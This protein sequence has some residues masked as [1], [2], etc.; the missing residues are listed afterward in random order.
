MKLVMD[1]TLKHRVVGL[2][3]IISL[4]AIFAPAIMKKSSERLEHHFSVNM[5]IPKQPLTPRLA[6]ADSKE[7][8]QTIK[9]ARV[10]I[11]SVSA[12][13]KLPQLAAAQPIDKVSFEKLADAPTHF[14]VNSGANVKAKDAV[15]L[16]ALK[17]AVKTPAIALQQKLA[18]PIKPTT[19]STAKKIDVSA[20]K[21]AAKKTVVKPQVNLAAK[22][23]L[24]KASLYAL[25]L[26]SFSQMSN[27]QSLVNK[28]QA[29]GY[30]ANF[31]KTLGKNGAI[32]KVF[33][34]HSASKDDVLK[35]KTQLASAMQLNGFVVN[36]GV[37]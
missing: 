11:Q 1:E 34:G 33:V 24:N 8:F 20:V 4:G 30:K 27:A 10:K 25:Q 23:N 35:L 9:V 6:K 7:M 21:V 19:K 36:T 3:V 14:A 28:L 26:A 32:Y 31:S 17:P 15:S 18:S 29:K 16:A 13:N 12:A 2:A 22:R 5:P 37:S